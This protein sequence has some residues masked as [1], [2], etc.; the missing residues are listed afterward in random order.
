MRLLSLGVGVCWIRGTAASHAG[1]ATLAVR[2]WIG[3]VVVVSAF[4]LCG[5]QGLRLGLM[6]G[7]SR[8]LCMGKQACSGGARQLRR[9]DVSGRAGAV[10][11]PGCKLRLVQGVLVT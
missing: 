2:R 5:T 11:L 6:L 3:V 1:R 8:G 9:Q 7:R 4:G 10:D